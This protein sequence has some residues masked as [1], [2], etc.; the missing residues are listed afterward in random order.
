MQRPINVDPR[1]WATQENLCSHGEEG[2]KVYIPWETHMAGARRQSKGQTA[3]R[4][5][6]SSQVQASDPTRVSP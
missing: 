1:G 3:V 5:E 4:L 2:G 6:G